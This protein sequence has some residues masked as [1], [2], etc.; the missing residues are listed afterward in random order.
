MYICVDFTSVYLHQM[1][2]VYQL[3]IY[4]STFKIPEDV[5]SENKNC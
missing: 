5:F 1:M 3:C 2:L 4:I